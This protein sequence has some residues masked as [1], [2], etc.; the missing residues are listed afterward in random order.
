MLNSIYKALL[1]LLLAVVTF[2]CKKN[3]TNVAKVEPKPNPFNLELIDDLIVVR[4]TIEADETVSDIL[5]PHSVTPQKIHEIELKALKVF[6]LSQFRAEKELYIYA[7]WDSVETVKY[8]VYV[9]DEIEQVVF[10]LRDSIKI[11]KS[12]RKHDVKQVEARGKIKS[13]L[14]QDLQE[15]GFHEDVGYNTADVFESKIDFM[16]L[17]D[18]DGFDI[19]FDQYYVEGKPVKVGK[20]YAAKMNHNK[21][22]YYA[23]LYDKEKPNSYYDE[24]GESLVGMFLTAPL[25]LRFRISS[26]YSKSRLHPVLHRRKAHLGT[27]FAAPHGSPIQSTAHGVVTEVGYNGGNG[28]YVKIKHN[29]TFSTQYLHMSRF[30]KGIRRGVKVS[31]GQ[32][33]GY[34]GA[35][36]LATGP[37]VCYRF[38]KNGKQVDPFKE[39]GNATTPLNK[40]HLNDFKNVAEKFKQRLDIS[41]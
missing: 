26:R 31:Q 14:I 20:V 22:N 29:A 7:K 19:I 10:D 27:D 4:D 30:A 13:G 6:P 25:K 33:I 2:S 16:R 23:F 3:E 37:H 12:Q 41:S 36:G 35:T 17:Q 5:T 9:I 28:N 8:M 34:V 24:K 40:K 1:L 21:K 32:I 39:K 18:G 15:L 38:W 11:Y